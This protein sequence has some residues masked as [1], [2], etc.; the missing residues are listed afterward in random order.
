MANKKSVLLTLSYILGGILTSS[1][2]TNIGFLGKKIALGYSPQVSFVN[3]AK[4][5]DILTHSFNAEF[6]TQRYQSLSISLGYKKTRVPIGT[7]ESQNEFFLQEYSLNG[8]NYNV[9]FQKMGGTSDFRTL[10]IGMKVNFYYQ[11]RTFAA[12]NGFCQYL[13]ADIIKVKPTKNNYTY[14]LLNPSNFSA[15]QIENAKIPEIKNADVT[16]LNIGFGLSSKKMLSRTVF[17]SA[18]I[19]T[20]INTLTFL[21]LMDEDNS[22]SNDINEDLKFTGRSI[23]RFKHLFAFGI[24][25]GVLL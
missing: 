3:F 12:P 1:A 17:I 6:S 25:V 23:N 13:K 8:Q 7:Y 15:A 2:Q 22:F 18:N 19:E 5:F 16:I 21:Y 14:E 20:N 11:G 10:M 24:G 9:D 4:G